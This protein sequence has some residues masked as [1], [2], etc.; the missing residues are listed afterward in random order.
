M[1]SSRAILCLLPV[2][3]LSGCGKSDS[4][5]QEYADAAAILAARDHGTAALTKSLHENLRVERGVVIVDGPIVA[6][7]V[8][9]SRNTAWSVSCG[10]GV[11]V[12]IG[13]GEIDLIPTTLEIDD[14]RCA[15]LT[16]R[17]GI[18]VQAILDGSSKIQ[19]PPS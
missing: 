14:V 11:A 1:S 16:K 5:N 19:Q 13:K 10:D 2:V 17:L 4:A 8:T 15:Y 6:G 18:E 12:N 7:A 9:L 3:F